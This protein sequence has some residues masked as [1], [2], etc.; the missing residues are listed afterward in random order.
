MPLTLDDLYFDLAKQLPDEQLAREVELARRA[1]TVSA[2]TRKDI[3]RHR[4]Y[5]LECELR[6]RA[7]QRD[8]RNPGLA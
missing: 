4:L 2:R 3:A 7:E 8:L 5:C 1:V 6:R